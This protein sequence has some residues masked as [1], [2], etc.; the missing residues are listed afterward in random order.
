LSSWGH[1]LVGPILGPSVKPLEEFE[2]A[3]IAAE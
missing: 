3:G 2:R 1:E